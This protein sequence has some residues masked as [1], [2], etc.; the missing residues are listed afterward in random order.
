MTPFNTNKENVEMLPEFDRHTFVTY[1]S[2]K[3]TGLR[4]YIAIHRK[5]GNL[6]SF[7]ATRMWKY[8][9]E[10]DA[11]RDAL[12]LSKMMSYKAA[13]AG[14]SC[15]GAK[16]VI[17]E[18]SGEYD[19]KA[20]L[21]SFADKLKLFKEHFVTGADVGLSQDDLF[22]MKK[23]AE[24][25]VGLTIDPTYFTAMGL[26]QSVKCTLDHLYGTQ[27]LTGR[28]FAIQGLGKIGSELLGLIYDNA[29]TIYVSDIDTTRVVETKKKYPKVIVLP[30]DQIH[31]QT[32]DIFSPC[33]LSH[34]LNSQIINDLA[35][36][37]VVGGANNQ[38]ENSAIGGLL[39]KLGVLYAPDY[40]VNAGGLIAV[41]DEYE[42][43]ERDEGR[44]VVKV[45]KIMDILEEIYN[46]SQAQNRATNE[47]ADLIAEKKFNSY[48]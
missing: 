7:G 32:V 35:C 46:I 23:H 27:N 26:F 6:P 43:L 34:A 17:I 31:K 42:Y 28:T 22:E 20:L 19:R 14:L 29:G 33:A 48:E 15:G 47:I 11:L 30:S 38:L 21:V 44:V 24:N 9:S 13:V 41:Y 16:A 12:R 1:V 39:H 3:K 40:V 37:S 36:K 18:P 8:D 10:K 5:N 45:S 4:A 2:D 25:I